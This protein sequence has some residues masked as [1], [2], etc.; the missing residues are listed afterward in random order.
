ALQHEPLA[1]LEL[2]QAAQVAG[3]ELRLA[4]AR[5]RLR[6]SRPARRLAARELLDDVDQLERAER[7]AQERVGACSSGVARRLASGQH[8]HG[9]RRLRLLQL[10]AEGEP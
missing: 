9:Q 1:A 2:E 6:A 7:L 5:G 4:G 3:E 10:P 8:E